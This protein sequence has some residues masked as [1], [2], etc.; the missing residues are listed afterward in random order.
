MFHQ[1]IREQKL[2]NIYYGNENK[3]ISGVITDYHEQFDLIRIN[4]KGIMLP[5]QCITKIEIIEQSMATPLFD[6]HQ[7]LEHDVD[8]DNAIFLA[9]YVSV[10]ID[11]LRIGGPAPV[12]WYNTKSVQVGQA[13]YDKRAC[14]FK[15]EGTA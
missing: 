10:W 12:K 8:F 7:V 9:Q 2:V 3:C 11:E 4:T 14:L 13:I 5:V 6:L 15:V 1:L